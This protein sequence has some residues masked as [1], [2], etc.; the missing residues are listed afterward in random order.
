MTANNMCQARM[1]R[2]KA[3]KE[4]YYERKVVRK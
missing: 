4:Q 3:R 1:R 2:V